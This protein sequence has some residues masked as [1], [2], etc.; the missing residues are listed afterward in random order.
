MLQFDAETT[1]LLDMA[2]RG[3]DIMRR[4]RLSFDALAP[5]PSETI[6][7]IGSG[8]GFLSAELALAVGPGGRVIGIDPSKD[9]RNSAIQRCK[10]FDWVSFRDGSVYDLPMETESVDKA[11]SVQVFEYLDDLP[12][13][14]REAARVLRIGGRLVISDIHF[15]SLIWHTEDRDRMNRMIK[16]WDGHFAERRV[17]AILPPIIRDAGC[18]VDDIRS[19]TITDHDLRPDG[20]ARMMMTLMESFATQNN[21]M[22]RD[23]AAAWRKEQEELAARGRFFFSITQFA[24]IARKGDSQA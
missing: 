8:S 15:D 4:R 17:P 5:K 13:A 21:L 9:M 19:V 6:L 1:R 20:L 7:D 18:S 22:P 23:E 3:S 16:A 2:Y 11:V 10:D 24:I 14:V 12:L